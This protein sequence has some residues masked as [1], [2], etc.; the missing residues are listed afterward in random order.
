MSSFALETTNMLDNKQ[1][2]NIAI[3]II[4]NVGLS[5]G[6]VMAGRSLTGLMIKVG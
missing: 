2:G 1:F 3:N 6:A 4:A 5:I